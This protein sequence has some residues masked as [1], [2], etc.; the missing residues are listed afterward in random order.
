MAAGD[1]GPVGCLKPLPLT[2]TPSFEPADFDSLY[3]EVFRTSCGTSGA[4]C[5][6]KAGGKAGLVFADRDQAYALLLG[7]NGGR[8]RVIPGDPEC[9]ILEQRVESDDA[10]F[11]MPRGNEPLN[12]GLRC[13]IRLWIADGAKR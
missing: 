9:S 5:H 4:Q 2:C 10:D 7:K 8:A 11:R 6:G 13:A 1:A 12:D 3:E